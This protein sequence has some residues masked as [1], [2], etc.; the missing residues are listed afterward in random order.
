M[1]E[2]EGHRYTWKGEVLPSVTGIIKSEG[3]PSFYLPGYDVRGRAVHAACDMDDRGV[4]D[5]SS[6]H[7]GVAPFLNGWRKLKKSCHLETGED[8]QLFLSEQPLV[9][10]KMGYAGTVDKVLTLGGGVIYVMDLKTN[11]HCSTVLLQLVA[12]MDMLAEWREHLGLPNREL[13]PAE[14]ILLPRSFKIKTFDARK[15]K[16]ARTWFKNLLKEFQQCQKPL[17][18]QK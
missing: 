2:P 5:E 6:V 18:P 15:I 3:K 13:I 4:L 10:P 12:Y 8:S 17:I 11:N 7:A 16:E 9:H 14:A 1:F